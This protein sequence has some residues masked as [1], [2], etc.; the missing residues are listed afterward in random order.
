MASG[1]NIKRRRAHLCAPHAQPSW[2]R[3]LAAWHGG[4]QRGA[5]AERS[6]AAKMKKAKRRRHRRNRKCGV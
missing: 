1:E 2:R 3:A 4:V 5:G 6:K